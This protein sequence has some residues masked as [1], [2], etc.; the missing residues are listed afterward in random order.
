MDNFE[1]EKTN[2]NG[3]TDKQHD[4]RLLVFFLFMVAFFLIVYGLWFYQQQSQAIRMDRINE[5]NSIAELK[6]NEIT[7]WRSERLADAQNYS[8][9]L[10][11]KKA[12]IQWFASPDDEVLKN[13]ILDSFQLLKSTYKYKD[14]ILADING[15]ISLS[16]DPQLSDLNS[17]SKQLVSFAI[18]ENS[19]SFGDFNRNA[20]NDE[21][22]LD[23]I[24][25]VQGVNGEPI[26]ALIFR[27]DPKEY[28]YP[29]IQ[30]WPT[31]SE[32]A[33]TLLIRK[34]GDQVL[35]LNLLRH[36]LAQP[37]TMTVSTSSLNIPAVQ[38]VLGYAGEFD[39]VDYRGEKV[40]SSIFPIPDS[41]WYM[42]AKVDSREILSEVRN[43]LFRVVFQDILAIILVFVLAAYVYRDRQRHLYG[44]LLE[45]EQQLSESQKEAQITLYSIGDAV[46]S[47]DSQGRVNRL[48]PVAEQ[49]TGWKEGDAKGE[50]LEKVFKI[51]NEQ[52]RLP[53]ENP[54]SQVLR[55]GVIIGLANHTL[56][57]AKDGSEK[58]IADSGAPIIDSEGNISGVVL[59]FRDQSEER[60]VQNEIA[61]LSDTIRAS[62]NEIYIFDEKNYQFKF[63]NDGAL[64]NIGYSLEQM[65]QKTPVDIKPEF[66]LESYKKHVEP[67]IKNKVSMLVFE[68]IQKRTDGSI[69]PVEVHLQ[70]INHENE[71]V[72]LA[73]INDI[74][75][76]KKAEKEIK[77]RDELLRLTGEMAK[78]GGWEFDAVTL[79]GSWT[80]EVARIH[81]LDPDRETNVALGTSFYKDESR[82][83]VEKAIKE[84]IESAKPYDLELEMIS[85]KGK[86]KTVRTMGLPIIEDGKVVKVRGIFQDITD[87]KRAEIK[88]KENEAR[89]E[90]AQTIAHVGNWEIIL[91]ENVMWA[92][93]EAFSIY[94]LDE[95]YPFVTLEIVQQIPLEDERPKLDAA[96]EALI[97]KNEKYDLEFRIRR[98]NDGVVRVVHS[99]A[100]L[101]YNKD[102]K[103]VK[104][105]GVIQDITEKKRVEEDLRK[106]DARFKT[107]FNH[108]AVGV[109]LIESKTGR[110]LDINKRYCD[111][112]GYTR[113]EMLNSS[114]QDVTLEEDVQENIDYVNLFLDR[115]INEFKIE[116]R[117]HRKDGAVVWGELTASPL[118]S[119]GENPSDYLHIA[120]VQDITQR[121]VSEEKLSEQLDELRRWHDATL[122]REKRIIDLKKEINELL[123]KAGLP[124]RYNREESMD[125]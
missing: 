85:A 47:T 82:I 4:G 24:A 29:L 7:Q 107:F 43:L 15:N 45:K 41:P 64:K 21:I 18:R 94:G 86:A 16:L 79:K 65:M 48:N 68:T 58:P 30:S 92:S 17:Y 23:V 10:F 117:Y 123:V 22:S 44:K 19:I 111:F 124:P 38:A 39:G 122:G 12:Y 87:Q 52:T 78:V 115:R 67:L 62:Q 75:I 2:L 74:T 56:L 83:K 49:L 28:L 27:I 66:T 102:G 63:I 71:R 110:Y 32:T 69:Y 98:V 59:V 26:G 51:I 73:V 104:V 90:R 70:L 50:P 81:D 25:A 34:E 103:P 36:S 37:M 106:S 54:V 77:L 6:V 100:T 113:E 42:I 118:W 88:I 13:A 40:M 1:K 31:P 5:L 97:Q 105:I 72:F 46:I 116:K 14:I 91:G 120:I 61:L 95:M 93:R 121:K 8:S 76:R 112:L 53:V 84:A 55:E 20:E 57:L 109:A 119:P 108:A 11:L 9:N 60:A 99:E 114:F 125:D 80:E 101:E 35:F 96:L 33:E 89:L 3:E